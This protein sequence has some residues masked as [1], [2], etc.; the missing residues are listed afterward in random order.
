MINVVIVIACFAAW[1][2]ISGQSCS[3]M[4]RNNSGESSVH[5]D[6]VQ[7]EHALEMRKKSVF[8]NLQ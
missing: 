1:F 3:A 7:L 4:V 2:S 8:R 5:S 6:Q